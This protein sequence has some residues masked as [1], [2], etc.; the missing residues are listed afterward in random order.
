ME[1]PQSLA[2]TH[3]NMCAVL[4]QLSKHKEAL[5]HVLLSITLLQDE[6]LNL[7][8]PEKNI[9]YNEKKDEENPKVNIEDRVSVL[10]IAYHNLGVE[11]EYLK[12][13]KI[14]KKIFLGFLILFFFFDKLVSRSNSN[15]FKSG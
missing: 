2:D 10:A 11:L 6:F 5:Q 12:R 8:P 13:V 7:G 1:N 14:L 9:D 4:S 15:I 3:L